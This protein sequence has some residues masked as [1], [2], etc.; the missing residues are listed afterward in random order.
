MNQ[1]QSAMSLSEVLVFFLLSS[2]VPHVSNFST[3]ALAKRAI[4]FEDSW[5]RKRVL[6]GGDVHVIRPMSTWS[7]CA[8]NCNREPACRSFSICNK[9]TCELNSDDRFSTEQ[10]EEILLDD[11]NCNYFGMQQLETPVCIENGFPKDISIDGIPGNCAINEKR[12]DVEWGRWSTQI[13]VNTTTEHKLVKTGR[14]ITV[15]SAHGGVD[16]DESET[17]VY[18]FQ[19][20][21]EKQTWSKAIEKC[22]TLGGRLFAD[23][24]GTTFQQDLMINNIPAAYYWLGLSKDPNDTSIIRDL[25]G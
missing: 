2:F 15:E 8:A 3:D 25:D 24:D 7:E 6:N 12:I 13:V 22:E 17:T 4:S 1:D 16:N 19:R 10:A 18:W 20:V 14:I 21:Y 11:E 5:P 23:L 9:L